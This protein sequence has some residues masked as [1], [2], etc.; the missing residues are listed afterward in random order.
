MFFTSLLVLAWDLFQKGGD[1]GQDS[2]V[3]WEANDVSDIRLLF[4][5][6]I[7]AG[8]AKPASARTRI[9]GWG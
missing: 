6:L 8:M 5:M 3:G 9:R 2:G 1:Q 7:D 4:Q